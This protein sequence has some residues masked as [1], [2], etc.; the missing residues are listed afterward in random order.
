MGPSVSNKDTQPGIARLRV[1]HSNFPDLKG[2]L[3]YMCYALCA[4][5][6]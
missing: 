1:L 6:Q 5:L 3:L 2:K 4:V